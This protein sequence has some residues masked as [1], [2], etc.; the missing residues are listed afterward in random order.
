MVRRQAISLGR[1]M[2][3]ET[4]YGVFSLVPDDIV[5]AAGIGVVLL[6]S[7]VESIIGRTESSEADLHES[8]GDHQRQEDGGQPE[9]KILDS[10]GDSQYLSFRSRLTC[11]LEE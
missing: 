2:I 9:A 1:V 11:R 4:V 3:L 8:G 5:V 10:V 6:A 7:I